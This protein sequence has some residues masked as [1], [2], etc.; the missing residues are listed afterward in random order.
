MG[1]PA[2]STSLELLAGATT[3]NSRLG[4]VVLIDADLTTVDEAAVA[5][6][7]GHAQVSH[8]GWLCKLART[9][10][11]V[12]QRRYFALAG[13]SL[14]CEQRNLP[15]IGACSHLV[16]CYNICRWGAHSQRHWVPSQP[17]AESTQ[18]S[19]CLRIAP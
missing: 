13:S 18:H 17:N 9:G 6:R 8:R 4:D 3:F 14:F 7:G 1:K 12:F 15:T 16:A 19:P 2:G 10:R 5:L 11:P